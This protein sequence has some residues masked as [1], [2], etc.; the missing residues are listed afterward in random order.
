MAFRIV[1]EPTQQPQ[2]VPAGD[3]YS[4]LRGIARTGA[5]V[6]ET[7]LGF[8]GDVAKGAAKIAT[9]STGG[10]SPSIDITPGKTAEQLR[11]AHE[12]VTGEYLKPQN[13]VESSLDDVITTATNLLIPG[14]GELTGATKAAQLGTQAAKA[15]GI[16]AGGELGGWAAEKLGA[17]E[18]GQAATKIGVMTALNLFGGRNRLEQQMKSNYKEAEEIASKSIVRVPSLKNTMEDF[19]NKTKV[20]GS[21]KSDIAAIKKAKEISKVITPEGEISASQLLGFKRKIN[22]IIEDTPWEMK[23]KRRNL[24]NLSKKLRPAIDELVDQNKEFAQFWQPAEEVWK[25]L[26]VQS[27][28]TKNLNKALKPKNKAVQAGLAGAL[29]ATLLFGGVKTLG[30]GAAIAAGTYAARETSKFLD[31]VRQSPIARR[32][33]GKLMKNSFAGNIRAAS[34]NIQ[35]LDKIAFKAEPEEQKGNFRI[36]D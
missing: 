27:Q 20:G 25:G 1:D 18:L 5:R 11:S 15:V 19:I 24:L 31:L 22:E 6:A 16:A 17:G 7:G 10:Y 13:T 8:L 32:E 33:Y 3:D 9:A 26:N 36:V 12:T 35:T 34:K 30:K 23:N 2:S 28:I 21:S 29:P 14:Y 4:I